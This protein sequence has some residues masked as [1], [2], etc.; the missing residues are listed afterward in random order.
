[1]NSATKA[2]LS[3]QRTKIFWTSIIWLCGIYPS[4]WKYPK[5]WRL[6]RAP[7]RN[8]VGLGNKKISETSSP[9]GKEGSSATYRAK[10]KSLWRRDH[11]FTQAN[12]STVRKSQREFSFL[13]TGK[14]YRTSKCH[15][16]N[17]TRTWRT[18]FNSDNPQNWNVCV[19]K[20]WKGSYHH[21]RNR[22]W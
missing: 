6:F 18:L 7:K 3:A 4:C 13:R 8:P 2:R 17:F 16:P 10:H 1:M 14:T 19:R 20:E 5:T 9:M 15:Q 12:I 22:N 11:P 21:G